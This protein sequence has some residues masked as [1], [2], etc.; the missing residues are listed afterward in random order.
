[1]DNPIQKIRI[2]IVED[3][4]VQAKKLKFLLEE[5]NYEVTVYSNGEEAYQYIKSNIPNLIISDIL[6]PGIDGYELCSLIKSDCLISHIPVILLTTLRD[7]SDII[8]GLQSQADNFIIKPYEDQSLLMRIQYLMTNREIPK[9][10]SANKVIEIEFQGQKFRINSQRKQILDLLLS[11]YEAAISRNEELIKTQNI[12]QNTNN[13]LLATNKE[14]EAFSHTVSHD[15]RSPIAQIKT[16][17]SIIE[18]DLN[19]GNQGSFKKSLNYISRVTDNMMMLVDELLNFSKAKQS[20]IILK[21]VNI[22]QIADQLID[23]LKL[24]NPDRNLVTKV[25]DGLVC[26]ADES[27]IYIVMENLLNNA[28]KYSSKKDP[29]KIEVGKITEN[30]TDTFYIKDNGIGFDAALSH[31][32]FMPFERLHSS[33]DYAGIGIGLATVKRI[34]ERH[35]GSIRAVSELNEGAVFYW[36]I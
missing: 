29:S 20:E 10:G 34:I 35:G 24:I 5:N 7:P 28:F 11:V 31:K 32:L 19:E 14:L 25:E 12:L 4:L 1:M 2:A 33:S 27:L 3:S 21:N 16:L 13:E 36:Q 15:L 22:T 26:R 30:G 8:K 17:V 9:Q 6:M 23:D 18:R